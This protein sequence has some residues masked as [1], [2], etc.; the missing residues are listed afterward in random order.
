MLRVARTHSGEIETILVA[1][2]DLAPPSIAWDGPTL[3]DHLGE[4]HRR[5]GARGPCLYLIRPDG[6]LGYRAI[7]PDAG[8]LADYLEKIFGKG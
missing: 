7:P 3:F 6:Y 5:F 4:L 8:K 2:G 1:R